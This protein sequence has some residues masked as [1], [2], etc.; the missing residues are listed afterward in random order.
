[1]K[2]I[3]DPGHGGKD[4]GGGNNKYFKEKDMTLKISIYQ[5]NRLK[6]LGVNVD[7]TRKEDVYLS[8]KN[9]TEIIRNSKA[10]IC[11]SNHINSFSNENVQGAE[12]IH[13]IYSDGEL[14]NILLNELVKN[15]AIRRRVFSKANP[16]NPNRD[17]YYMNRDTASVETVIVEYGFA[18]NLSDTQ[19]LLNNWMDYAEAVVKGV[20]NYIN[21][22]YNNI[23]TSL[24]LVGPSKASLL[25]METWARN[26]RATYKFIDAAKLYLKYGS[27]TK[28]R[29]DILYCQSAKET[30]FGKYTGVVKE[31]MNNFAGI[32]IKNPTGDNIS[33]HETFKSIEDGVRAHFNHMCAYVGITPIG[34]PHDRYYIVK[35]LDWASTVRYV[36]ELGGKWAP[37]KNYGVSIK[38]LLNKLLNTEIDVINYKKLYEKCLKEREK[39]NYEIELLKEKINKI[40]SIVE[41]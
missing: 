14:A 21:H 9:R 19:K 2:I 23:N 7:I 34:I 25:Q 22:P 40:K 29:G 38:N 10:D 35:S 3:I 41:D 31:E 28:L 13:S 16:Q 39:L 17:Y 1:M 18:S 8:P 33:D 11:I 20:C 6:E 32:K 15:G 37:D 26:N 24:K 27:L 4:P 12:I 5:Y 36:E 30:N